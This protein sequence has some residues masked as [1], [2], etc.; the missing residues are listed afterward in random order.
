MTATVHRPTER[1]VSLVLEAEVMA[2]SDTGRLALIASTDHHM[3][4]LVDVS[5]ARLRQMVDEARTRLDEFE[6]LASEYEARD[7]LSAILAEH[8][9][10]LIEAPFDKLA[11][12]DGDLATRLGCWVMETPDGRGYVVVP[13]DQDPIERLETVSAFVARRVRRA[14]TA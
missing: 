6:R 9:L 11:S 12:I 1:T 7:T 3:T 13:S 5:P 14:V 4:D 10:T 2:D 8:D